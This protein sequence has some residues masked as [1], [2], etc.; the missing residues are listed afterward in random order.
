MKWRWHATSFQ[1]P[2]TVNRSRQW[3][4]QRQDQRQQKPFGFDQQRPDWRQ[5]GGKRFY[6]QWRAMGAA[7]WRATAR[8]KRLVIPAMAVVACRWPVRHNHASGKCPDH[9]QCGR[10]CRSQQQRRNQPRQADR[11]SDRESVW[12]ATGQARCEQPVR[13]HA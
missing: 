9:T 13:L 1:A 3:Q 5:S 12:Q 8:I 10:H 6:S 11:Q 2:Q 4:R 7:R